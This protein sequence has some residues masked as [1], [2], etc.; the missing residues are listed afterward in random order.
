MIKVLLDSRRDWLIFFQLHLI[1]VVFTGRFGCCSVQVDGRV[2]AVCG[3]QL[4][5][6][7][8]R[9][10]GRNR[11]GSLTPFNSVGFSQSW[12]WVNKFVFNNRTIK[13][14]V[15]FSW[16]CPGTSL[17]SMANL[18]VYLWLYLCS[19]G[20]NSQGEVEWCCACQLK[21]PLK[22]QRQRQA[23]RNRRK[24]SEPKEGSLIF[25]SC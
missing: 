13:V 19:S 12:I 8:D 9:V 2:S 25:H 1:N 16:W 5:C 14:C 10:W 11:A 4:G 17:P 15:S 21:K 18:T 20:S 3:R 7:F 23:G 22:G 6:E 24:K